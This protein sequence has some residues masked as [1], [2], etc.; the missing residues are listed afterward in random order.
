MNS[1]VPW[2]KAAIEGAAICL[3]AE[4]LVIGCLMLCWWA[5]DQKARRARFLADD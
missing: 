2:W 3:A 5:A 4:F 1:L